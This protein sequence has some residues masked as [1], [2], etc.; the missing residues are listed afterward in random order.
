MTD[1]ETQWN[2]A[3][4]QLGVAPPD[5]K[6]LESLLERYAEPQRHYHTVQHLAECLALF[7]QHA[8]LA[9]HPGEVALALFYHDA[10]YR[11]RGGGNEEA[12]ADLAVDVAAA[13]GVESTAQA[14]IR[15]LI[16]ATRHTAVPDLPDERLLVDI[17]LAILAAPRTRFDAY[18]QQIRAEY[19]WV[20]G[21]LFRRKRRAILRSFLERRPLFGTPSLAEQLEEQARSNLQRVLDIR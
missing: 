21:F 8:G 10:I 18:E 2:T 12:S 7:E 14:R 16:L 13:A 6:V 17:D 1:L 5:K 20:P 19:G 3:W 11:V 9:Q 15:A 4:R